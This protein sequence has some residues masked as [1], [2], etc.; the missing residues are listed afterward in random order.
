MS[1]GLEA[2]EKIKNWKLF[3]DFEIDIDAKKEFGEEIEIIETELK[4]LEE[5][6]K[7]LRSDLEN[8]DET[9]FDTWS[10]CEELKKNSNYALMFIDNIYCLVDTKDNK[11]EVIDN[12]DINSKGIIDK[13]SKQDEILRIIKESNIISLERNKETEKCYINFAFNRVQIGKQEFDLLKEILC[14]K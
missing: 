10:A 4:R 13:H 5:E 9:Y 14:S 11:F 3:V 6:N 8:L 7:Y 1:K 2:L 12:Y